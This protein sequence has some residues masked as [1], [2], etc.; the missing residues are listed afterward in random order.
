MQCS[1]CTTSYCE[2]G[3]IVL[4][5]GDCALAQ[6]T[7]A[8]AAARGK[9]R[10]AV[11]T[12][13]GI[14]F[15]GTRRRQ[16]RVRGHVKRQH[17]CVFAACARVFLDIHSMHRCC[18]RQQRACTLL[19]R[20]VRTC[21]LL[22]S[23]TRRPCS[24]RASETEAFLVGTYMHS[25]CSGVVGARLLK[26][27]TTTQLGGEPNRCMREWPVRAPVARGQRGTCVAM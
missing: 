20:C 15:H 10:Q 11:M 8:A 3:A 14:F 22:L 21:V 2:A 1:G 6:D 23:C 9:G 19:S 27:L 12:L 4:Y 26:R 24:I 13:L 5:D 16:D 18:G 25:V 17:K 7:A